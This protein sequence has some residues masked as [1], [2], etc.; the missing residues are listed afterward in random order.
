MEL[1][2]VLE[3]YINWIK[4]FIAE[5]KRKKLSNDSIQEALEVYRPPISEDDYMFIVYCHDSPESCVEEYIEK[6]AVLV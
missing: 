6:A 4:M 5:A 1:D 3:I 2:R